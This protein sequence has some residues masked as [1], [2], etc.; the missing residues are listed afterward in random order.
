M[1]LNPNS[2]HLIPFNKDDHIESISNLLTEYFTWASKTAK[3]T[4]KINLFEEF[5]NENLEKNLENSLSKLD[6]Y[7]PPEGQLLLIQ[8]KDNEITGM[9]AL[10]KI[11][12][13]DCEI[14]RMFVSPRY[15]G[16]KLGKKL[17]FGLINLAKEIGYDSIYLDS[18]IFMK[19]AQNTVQRL[20]M[21]SQRCRAPSCTPWQG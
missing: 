12:E 20:M 4:I 13:N 2:F 11:H 21:Y 7:N 8:G 18:A 1:S 16:L 14:K 15:R 3:E 10:K 19:Q 5:G 9:G 17:L 6:E